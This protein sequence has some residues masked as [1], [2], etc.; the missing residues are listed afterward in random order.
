MQEGGPA[1]DRVARPP[2]HVREPPRDAGRAAQSGAGTARPRDHRN[3][4]ALLAPVT[5]GHAE[6]G[7]ASGP[8]RPAGN[9][10]HTDST[11][12]GRNRKRL[13]NKGE[14]GGVF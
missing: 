6:R 7:S 3:D 5:A 13:E 4:D 1:E 12:R 2:A 9:Q 11:W 8:Q 10:Q 14:N